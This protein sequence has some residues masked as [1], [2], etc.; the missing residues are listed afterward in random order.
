MPKSVSEEERSW[1]LQIIVPHSMVGKID[2][3]YEKAGYESRSS[4]LRDVLTAAV[5]G[6]IKPHKGHCTPQL[7]DALQ[8]L[9][10][11]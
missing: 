10:A 6:K 11:S 3:V 1:T 7:Y 9:Q 5:S 4:F 2:K 8:R